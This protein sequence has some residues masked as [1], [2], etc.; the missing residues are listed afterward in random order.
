MKYQ[1][2]CMHTDEI[3]FE[4][5][6]ALNVGSLWSMKSWEWEMLG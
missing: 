2:K 1:V 3:L 6:V 4:G 5:S